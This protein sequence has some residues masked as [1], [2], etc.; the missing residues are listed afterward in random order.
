MS[1]DEDL[2]LRRKDS[3]FGESLDTHN[4]LSTYRV[5][6]KGHCYSHEVSKGDD[7]VGKET[8]EVPI[9]L[10]FGRRFSRKRLT[11]VQISRFLLPSPN[12]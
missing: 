12:Y 11:F 8:L 4:T 10:T 2:D 5:T 3:G 9:T 1:H 7:G 6:Y